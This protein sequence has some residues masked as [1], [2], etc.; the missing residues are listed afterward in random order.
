M[1]IWVSENL[2]EVRNCHE[3]HCEIW[4]QR[5]HFGPDQRELLSYAEDGKVTR[6][7]CQTAILPISGMEAGHTGRGTR[8]E[9]TVLMRTE[10]AVTCTGVD[11]VGMQRSRC[12]LKVCGGWSYLLS[13]KSSQRSP[14]TG[15]KRTPLSVPDVKCL[16]SPALFKANCATDFCVCV[17]PCGWTTYCIS[18]WPR[19]NH[20]EVSNWQKASQALGY[21][22]TCDL[23]P[24][25]TIF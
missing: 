11:E 24:G 17:K 13:L 16:P 25:E 19:L 12:C 21:T 7:I 14:D 20:P 6:F 2:K 3:K 5:D 4:G 10:K 18:L 9:T 1:R 22:G 15:G 8:E 23:G